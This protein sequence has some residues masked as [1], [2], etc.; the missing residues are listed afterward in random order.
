MYMMILLS[1]AKT[2]MFEKPIKIEAEGTDGVLFLKESEKIAGIMKKKKPKDL[3][4]LMDISADL[5]NLNV[6]R[7][8]LWDEQEALPALSVFYG[9]VY[10]GLDAASFSDNDLSFAQQSIRIIS[11]LYGMLKPLDN[12]KPYRLEM[13]SKLK[14]SSKET[15]LYK[16]WRP[17]LTSYVKSALSSND[18]IVNLASNEYS[19]AIDFKK[20]GVPVYTPNFKEFR[21]GN[22]VS[23]MTYAKHARGEMAAWI[24]KNRITNPKD[25]FGFNESGYTLNPELSTDTELLFTR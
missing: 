3:V 24:V 10:R 7:Y 15:D 23:L 5:A 11:G 21:N 2:M 1:P 4:E 16:F 8:K 13:G 19:K 12:V 9:E 22:Y 18:F 14:V 6:H 17:R 20:I 25:L